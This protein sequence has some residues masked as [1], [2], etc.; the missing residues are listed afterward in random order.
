MKKIL[1]FMLFISLF[2]LFG[3]SKNKG[4]TKTIYVFDTTVT[5]NLYEG[6]ESNLDDIIDI[7]NYYHKLTDAYHT[8]DGITNVKK[9][10]DE[11]K[12]GQTDLVISKDLA[13]VLDIPIGI[14]NILGSFL[15][16]DKSIMLG[17]GDLTNLWKE[18]ISK[19]QLP[20][21]DTI[22]QVVQDIKDGKY[23]YTVSVNQ[24]DGLLKVDENSK[25]QFDLGAITKGYV[26]TIIHNY[27]VENNIKKYMIDLGQ[28]TILVGEK[29]NGK[30]FNILVN[31]TNYVLKDVKNSFIGTASVLEQKTIINGKTYHHIIDPTTGYPTD[32]YD[33]V[34]VVT[35]MLN[36]DKTDLL[37]TFLMINP[38]AASFF[39]G[40]NLDYDYHIHFFKDGKLVAGVMPLWRSI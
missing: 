34:V 27:L 39:D 22:N 11:I 17:I 5:I 1:T 23:N 15:Q 19:M 2:S 32:T 28:S 12:S 33:T 38:D 10:N 35:P 7:L 24:N 8:Y 20:N 30:G 36:Y 31:G 16:I 40:A 9:V 13:S 18:A 37:S 21:E 29:E 4:F 3:C 25:V 26:S 14:V 6:E